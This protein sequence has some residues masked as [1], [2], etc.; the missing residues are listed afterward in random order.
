RVQHLSD[1]KKFRDDQK[2][3]FEALKKAQDA[4]LQKIIGT[5]KF[6]KLESLRAEK[7]EKMKM[8]KMKHRGEKTPNDS[9]MHHEMTSNQM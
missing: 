3:K 2:A 5:E 7:Q 6:Q 8:Q 1:L 9:T 4:D